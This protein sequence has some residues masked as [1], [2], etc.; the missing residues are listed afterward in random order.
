MI[1]FRSVEIDFDVH[2]R[3][4][5]ARESFSETPNAV[6]RRLLGIDASQSPLRPP[7]VDAMRAWSGKGVLLPHGTR[8]RMDYNGRTHE[9][10]IL[11]GSWLVEGERFSS[12]SAAA[13]GVARTKDGKRTNLDGWIYWWVMLPGKETWKKLSQMRDG[14]QGV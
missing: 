10:E 3:I 14:E 12:P 1:E 13:G 2:K 11:D 8:V 4:E 5:L 7:R 9:G 6:L